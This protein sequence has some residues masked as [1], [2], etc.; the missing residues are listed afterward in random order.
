MSKFEAEREGVS[1]RSVLLGLGAAA[2][3]AAA[4]TALPPRASAAPSADAAW[5]PA[6]PEALGAPIAGLSYIGFDA[7]AFLP[8]EPQNRVG[9]DI[10][11]TGT[12]GAPNERIWANIPLPAG[13]TIYQMNERTRAGRGEGPQPQISNEMREANLLGSGGGANDASGGT[14]GG[15]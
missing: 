6:V 8:S 1:R 14:P 12:K 13:S 2:G 4:V 9:G 10:D 15:S 7:Q 5:F 3:A 11:L